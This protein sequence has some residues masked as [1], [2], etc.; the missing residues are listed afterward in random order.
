MQY[1]L[2]TVV[3][4]IVLLA[5]FVWWRYT[6]VARGVRQVDETILPLVDPIAEKLAMGRQPSFDEIESVASKPYA[7]PYLYAALK[8]FERLDLFPK[9]LTTPEAQAESILVRWMMHPNEFQDAPERIELVEKVTREVDGEK[10]DFYVFRFQ[11]HDGHWDAKHGWLLGMAGPYFENDVPYSGIAGAFSRG[12]DK[13]GE[14]LPGD[15][16]D[17]YISMATGKSASTSG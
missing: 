8:H 3:V 13:Y 17:W 10:A 5:A 14:V 15:L 7:R 11:M 4:I 9:Q 6:S 12:D 16:V 2:A 1:I